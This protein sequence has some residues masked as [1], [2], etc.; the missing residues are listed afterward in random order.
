MEKVFGNYKQ[1]L[2]NSE[3]YVIYE[4]CP[5]SQKLQTKDIVDFFF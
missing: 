3:I 5:F 1:N 2:M 4:F